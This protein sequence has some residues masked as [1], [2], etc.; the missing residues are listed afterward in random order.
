[1]EQLLQD[2]ASHVN[3]L[4][5]YFA[6]MTEQMDGGLVPDAAC[7]QGVNASWEKLRQ[8]YDDIRAT[9]LRLCDGSL[10]DGM[11]PVREY[12]RLAE[13]S[14][15]RQME[16]T[17]STAVQVLQKFLQVQAD[18][19]T[20]AA[21]LEPYQR[22][23]AELL[24]TLGA[25][26]AALPDVDG[27]KYFLQLLRVADLDEAERESLLDKV[28]AYFSAKV[29]RGL[30]RGHYYLPDDAGEAAPAAPPAAVTEAPP[31]A[32]ADE[33]AALPEA[34]VP[35]ADAPEEKAAA[36]APQPE[37]PALPE[38]APALAALVRP[39]KQSTPSASSLKKELKGLGAG[40]YFIFPLLS[41]FGLL[42]EQQIVD[43][44][45]ILNVPERQC[46][47]AV[48]AASLE[49]MAARG[50]L[51]EYRLPLRQESLYCYSPYGA[52]C[53]KK[54]S[55]LQRLNAQAQLSF[56][57]FSFLARDD[58][59]E[60]ELARYARQGHALLL[61][62]QR[63]AAHAPATL[64]ALWDSLAW[65]PAGYRLYAPGTQVFCRLTQ[66]ADLPQY[67][68]DLPPLLA[69]DVLPPPEMT[70]GIPLAYAFTDGLCCGVTDTQDDRA[71]AP[72]EAPA[73]PPQDGGSGPAPEA[74]PAA[75]MPAAQT[76]AAAPEAPAET[77]KSP[78][79]SA[80]HTETMFPARPPPR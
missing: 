11:L 16:Q 49:A 34:Q 41:R 71:A 80:N 2:F 26:D 5:Q 46:K 12:A 39:I 64:P 33:A 17:R 78:V 8:C 56:G 67:A 20:F 15:R 66:A 23:S 14:C 61:L 74:E 50:Y 35:A 13:E 54:E 36:P 73:A 65:E 72:G 55:S 52:G 53:V 21:A 18:Q 79:R 22:Q 28:D 75:A 38:K 1:M 10:P 60:A 9:A 59:P 6:A 77:A 62:L 25:Q 45:K 47:P 51:S 57:D 44:G 43:C 69:D 37:T 40:A 42:T 58:L 4:Q 63:V 24:E 29:S 3:A 27:Q 31:P 30:D 48:V 70:A 76:P 32:A 7:L 68:Q 19:P